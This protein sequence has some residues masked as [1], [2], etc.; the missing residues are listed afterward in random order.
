MVV[1]PRERRPRKL[2]VSGSRV[3]HDLR[4]VWFLQ[5]PAMPPTSAE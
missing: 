2:R 1:R 3:E 4:F 5:E